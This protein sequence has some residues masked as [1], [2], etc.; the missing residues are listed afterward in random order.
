MKIARFFIALSAPPFWK[1]ENMLKP[2]EVDARIITAITK[3]TPI[4]RAM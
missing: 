4:P 2:V 3:T 1:G